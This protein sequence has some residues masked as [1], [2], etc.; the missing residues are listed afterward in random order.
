MIRADRIEDTAGL[1]V[2]VRQWDWTDYQKKDYSEETVRASRAPETVKLIPV[3]FVDDVTVEE[4]EWLVEYSDGAFDKMTY[5]T[6]RRWFKG[7][8]AC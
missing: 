1:A 6:F 7:M 5:A 2:D 4:G 3:D 8:P